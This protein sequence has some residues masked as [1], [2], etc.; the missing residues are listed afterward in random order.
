M[1]TEYDVSVRGTYNILVIDNKT[2]ISIAGVVL[3]K[4]MSYVV[5]RSLQKKYTF[6]L[7]F[8]VGLK[9][10]TDLLEMILGNIDVN[11]YSKLL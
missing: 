3:R 6:H 4:R 8:Y 1:S 11:A 7:V 9:R 10:Q 5:I 2:L